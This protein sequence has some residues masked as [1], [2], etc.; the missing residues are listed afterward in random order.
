[1][2]REMEN[3]VESAF[4]ASLLQLSSEMSTGSVRIALFLFPVPFRESFTLRYCRDKKEASERAGSK[5]RGSRDAS[6]AARG[7]TLG[8][9]IKFYD[10][11]HTFCVVPK[12][13]DVFSAALFWPGSHH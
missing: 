4:L 3:I 1:M 6:E 8:A 9:N 5:S 10:P 12:A 7:G 13:V 11:A 2:E